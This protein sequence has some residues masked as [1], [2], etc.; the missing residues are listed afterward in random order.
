M[1]KEITC[2]GK[3][4]EEFVLVIKKPN[5]K[6]ISQAQLVYN[7]AF[8]EALDN[9]SILSQKMGEYLKSQGLWD[10]VREAKYK[11]LINQIQN[12][13]VILEKGGI[14]LKKA[15]DIAL[16]VRKS[17]TELQQLIGARQA[18]D[19]NCAEGQANNAQFDYLVSS[20]VFRNG[21][22]VWNSVDEY[23]VDSEE[24][25]AVQAASELANIMYSIDPNFEQN[26]P[27]NKFL[28]KYKFVDEKLNFINKDGHRVDSQGRLIDENDRFIKYV[29]GQKVYVNI[30]GEEVDEKGDLKVDFTPFLDDEGLPVEA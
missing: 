1:E 23:Y 14:P 9:G 22:P 24:D 3:D 13:S 20:C 17:R 8:R 15:R 11:S 2:K 4:G 30:N 29:D 21:A 10:D 5:R 18:Y 6:N 26:L 12:Y 19:S 16:D 25:W 7:K 27:E 28:I